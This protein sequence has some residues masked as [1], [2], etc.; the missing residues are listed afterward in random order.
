MKS[1]PKTTKLASIELRGRR[2]KRKSFSVDAEGNL[3]N[4]SSIPP[5]KQI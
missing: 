1:G 4:F 2:M 5:I 3:S